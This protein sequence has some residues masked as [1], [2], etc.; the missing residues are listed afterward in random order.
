MLFALVLVMSLS[1]EQGLS[2]GKRM[3]REESDQCRSTQLCGSQF[4]YDNCLCDRR[5]NALF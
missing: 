4:P 5:L 3:R 1:R 2:G